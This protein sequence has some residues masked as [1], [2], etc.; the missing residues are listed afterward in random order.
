MIQK[1]E[2]LYKLKKQMN[3]ITR[4]GGNMDLQEKKYHIHFLTLKIDMTTLEKKRDFTS[5]D[6]EK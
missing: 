1:K 2:N 4:R 6:T 3:N 5:N